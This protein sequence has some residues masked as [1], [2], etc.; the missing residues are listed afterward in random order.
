MQ[1]IWPCAA[2]CAGA[3]LIFAAELTVLGTPTAQASVCG[4]V[5]GARVDI[6]GCVSD[7]LISGAHR[8]AVRGAGRTACRRTCRDDQPVA[9]PRRRW[10]AEYIRY[11]QRSPAPAAGRAP[12]A[13]QACRPRW[14]SATVRSLGGTRL[15][16]SSIRPRGVPRHGVMRTIWCTSIARPGW[17][18]RL[19]RHLDLDSGRVAMYLVT[20]AGGGIGSVSRRVVKL[21]LD[22]GEQVR[23]MVRRDDDRADQ[24][25]A[26]GADVIVGDLTSAGDIVDAMDGVAS[27]VLQHE[28]VTRLS[29]G[30]HGGLRRGARTGPSRRDRQHVPD[31]RVADD[32]DEHR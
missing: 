6:S 24:L 32:A 29:A 28:R 25:R 11:A 9:V 5:G 15:S 4:S 16:S 10:Q 23:G 13:M 8:R 7:E 27:H 26:M 2:S 14:S 20:G 12:S 30:H 17:T 22:G 21:L 19:D 31:D 1:R 3:A 18:G